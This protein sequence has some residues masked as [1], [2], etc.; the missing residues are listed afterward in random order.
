MLLNKLFFQ[1]LMHFQKKK[2]Q[3]NKETKKRG[4]FPYPSCKCT[5]FHPALFIFFSFSIGPVE[6]KAALISCTT[7]I[8]GIKLYSCAVFR[9]A[10]WAT[11]P[12]WKQ[13]EYNKAARDLCAVNSKIYFACY[14]YVSIWQICQ[15]KSNNEFER[16]KKTN[17]QTKS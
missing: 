9:F 12:A 15:R 11:K 16:R 7:A 4:L 2:K 5:T 13:S 6:E 17:K 1:R 8:G 3:K 10:F 14:K